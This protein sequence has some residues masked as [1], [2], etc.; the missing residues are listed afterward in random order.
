[1][2]WWVCGAGSVSDDGVLRLGWAC[3]GVWRGLRGWR[4]VSEMAGPTLVRAGSHADSVCVPVYV[5][6][7]EVYGGR[8]SRVS[9]SVDA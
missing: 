3:G 5:G 4:E 2:S 9:A 6:L 8:G 7:G 1:M